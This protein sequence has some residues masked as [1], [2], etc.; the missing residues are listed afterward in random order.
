MTARN[1]WAGDRACPET[2]STTTTTTARMSAVAVTVGL[3]PNG[4]SLIVP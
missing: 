2:P 3:T 4:D 1:W